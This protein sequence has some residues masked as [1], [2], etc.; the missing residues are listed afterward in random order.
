M[1]AEGPPPTRHGYQP[2]EVVSALQK[3]IRR[4]QVDPAMYWAA[5]LDR[6]GY[7]AWLWKRLLVIASEDVGAADTHLVATIHALREIHRQMAKKDPEEGRLQVMH[8]T[9]ALATAPKS[10]AIVMACC[11]FYTDTHPRLEIPDEALDRHTARGK[12]MGR[13]WSHFREHAAH[14]EHHRPVPEEAEWDERGYAAIEGTA[15]VVNPP[16]KV[17]RGQRQ[18]FEE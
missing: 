17:E 8:A 1:S 3:A 7:T 10:R 9:Y 2:H 5:E 18:L 14:L 13:A 16:A 11:W 12:R 4:R 15:E 6:S